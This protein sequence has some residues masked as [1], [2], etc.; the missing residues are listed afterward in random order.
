MPRVPSISGTLSWGV[1][2]RRSVTEVGRVRAGGQ[3]TEGEERGGATVKGGGAEGSSTQP[4]PFFGIASPDFLWKR[5]NRIFHTKPYC[6]PLPGSGSNTLYY[7]HVRTV[8]VM[9]ERVGEEGRGV[10]RWKQN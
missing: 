7:I 4:S 10:W 1:Y 2:E 6:I 5:S 8:A 3:N 9:T